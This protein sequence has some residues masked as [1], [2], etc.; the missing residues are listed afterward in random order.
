MRKLVFIGAFAAAMFAST[1]HAQFGGGVFVCTNCADEPTSLAQK[2]TQA[3]Q[4]LKEAQTALNAVQM[5]Q[6]MARAGL[7]LVKHP[8]TNIAADIGQFTSILAASQGLAKDL[9]T[10]DVAFQSQYGSY[11]PNPLLSFATKYN[12]WATT[13]MKTLSG[14]LGAAGYQANGLNS[15]QLFLAQ[16]QQQTQSPQGEMEALQLGNTIGSQTVPQL[17]K[18]RHKMQIRTRLRTRTGRQTQPSGN[19][20]ESNLNR[21]DSGSSHGL[22]RSARARVANSPRA[23]KRRRWQLEHLYSAWTDAVVFD[24]PSTSE[25]DRE[26]V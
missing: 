21:N 7:N 3:M 15:D 10:M 25:E 17:L 20:N 23:R 9:A 16:V 11:T 22:L 14:S 6:L 13:T 18:R 2:A 12:T 4:Y 1:A 24:P 19:A 5:A 8:S 26:G